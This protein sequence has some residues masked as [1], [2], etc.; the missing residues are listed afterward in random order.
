[1]TPRMATDLELAVLLTTY[2]RPKHLER[3]LASLALQRNMTGRFEVVVCDDGS[4]DHTSEVV[5]RFA[6]A[7]DFPL[8]LTT[9][10]HRGFRVA[11]CRNDGVRATTAP[12][13]LFS[14]SD[15]IFPPDHLADHLRARRPGV[16]RAGNCHWLTREDTERL[17]LPAVASGV[18]RDRVAQL[19]RL[20]MFHRWAKEKYYELVHHPSKPK[21]TGCNIGISRADLEAVNGFD[22]AFV[23]WGC[24]DDDLAFRL[25]KAGKR[26]VTALGYT[27]AYHMWHP[28]DPTAPTK[29]QHGPNVERLQ[30]LDR[31]IRCR[32]GLIPAISVA[33]CT[34]TDA[35][36]DVNLR[37]P[38]ASKHAA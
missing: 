21:L 37:V 5:R 14:D 32:A 7:V 38:R 2:E 27:F 20:R 4:R 24:E 12:Y 16:V 1:V 36:E 23:G 19:D 28:T 13:L 3:S 29:W 18:Y 35:A 22:E 26:I 8:S 33:D 11:L 6:S 30:V 15:C 25:R 31:P 9:H 34:S 10:P 17:D